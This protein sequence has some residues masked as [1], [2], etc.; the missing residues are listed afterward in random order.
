MGSSSI[1]TNRFLR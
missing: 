1:V